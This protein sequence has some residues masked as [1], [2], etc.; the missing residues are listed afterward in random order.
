M[1]KCHRVFC[2]FGAS[3]SSLAQVPAQYVDYV[4][5]NIGGIGQLLTST[6]PVVQRRHG[7]AILAPITTPGIADRYLADKI[8]GFP[9]GLLQLQHNADLTLHKR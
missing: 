1:K 7:M 3:L 8:F 6:R 9:A 4:S 5:P 2:F